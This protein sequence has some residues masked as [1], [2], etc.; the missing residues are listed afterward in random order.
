MALLDSEGFGWSTAIADFDSYGALNFYT[1]DDT[2]IVTNGPLGDNWL[3]VG[4]VSGITGTAG[5]YLPSSYT[6]L[7]C[8]MRVNNL[9]SYTSGIPAFALI[10][11]SGGTQLTVLINWNGNAVSLYRGSS[12]GGTLLGTSASNVFPT[13]GWFYLE[14]GAVIATGTS[15]S[16]TVR[17]N[18]G[19]VLS[20]TGIDTQA[21]GNANAAR[22]Y[23]GFPGGGSNDVGIAH[24]YMCDNTGSAPWNTFL[25]DTRVQTLLPTSN[26]TVQFTPNGLGSNYQNA[27]NVPP[28]PATDYNSDSTVGDQDTFN[29]ANAATDTTAVWGVHHKGLYLKSDS[30]SRFME[31]VL[32]SGSTTSL[33]TSTALGTSAQ[34]VRTMFQTDPHT[35]AQW[36]VAAVSACKPGYRVSA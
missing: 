17:I 28:V 18:N 22:V 7:F 11:S 14:L 31:S 26:A 5:R 30:G 24:F 21:T 36:T 19:A 16:A 10:D 6:T 2:S 3:K 25:G 35:S 13:N 9:G 20:L 12:S 29:I 8:G 34:Q 23:W 4:S 1:G 27:A 33:G 15:G 32:V